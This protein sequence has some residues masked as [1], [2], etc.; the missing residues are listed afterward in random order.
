MQPTETGDTP[1]TGPQIEMIGV[2]QHQIGAQRPYFVRTKG[3]DGGLGA[4]RR[5]TGQGDLT[6]RCIERPQASQP[7]G[8]NE[9][10]A[11]RHDR[12]KPWRRKVIEAVCT[13]APGGWVRNFV[14]R[15]C[16][17]TCLMIPCRQWTDSIGR[18]SA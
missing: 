8:G 4:D 16:A 15:D 10:V 1:G 18:R 9:L 17:G 7:V 13:Q 5:K 3:L 11:E 14:L 12:K 6:V 2:G